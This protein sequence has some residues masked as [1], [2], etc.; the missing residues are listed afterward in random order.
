MCTF[1]KSGLFPFVL[2]WY[3]CTVSREASGSLFWLRR[4]TSESSSGRLTSCGENS[5]PPAPGCPSGLLSL[6]F[7]LLHSHGGNTHTHTHTQMIWKTKYKQSQH[8]RM[9]PDG[10]RETAAWKTLMIF[11]Q[12]LSAAQPQSRSTSTNNPQF[13]RHNTETTKAL[14]VT[15][16]LP[17]LIPHRAAGENNNN[18]NNNDV[19]YQR[20]ATQ[21]RATIWQAKDARSTAMLDR[22]CWWMHRKKSHRVDF[23]RSRLK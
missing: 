14:I 22:F 1:A 3:I 7:L 18:N 6:F 10:E 12:F 13:I 20:P 23:N 19:S 17:V 4:G 21:Q 5:S 15:E 9:Q 8:A 11:L 2:F 16:H